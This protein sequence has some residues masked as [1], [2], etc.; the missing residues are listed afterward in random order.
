MRWRGWAA[1]SVV[2][3]AC[4]GVLFLPPI[5]QSE[6]YHRFADTRAFLGVPN[7][8]NVVS[9]FFFLP[10]GVLGMRFV[11][12]KWAKGGTPFLDRRER[13]TYFVFFLAVA[14]TAFG[15][16]Y[17]HWRP[18]DQTLV[19]DRLPMTMGFGSL[20]AATVAERVNL[21]LGLRLL[22]PLL[23]IEAGTVIYW[24]ATQ[25]GGHGDLRPY[26]LAQFGSLLVIVLLVALYPPRYTRGADLLIALGIYGVAKIFEGADR[27]IFSWGGIV[28][29]HTLKHVVAALS[30][31]W[32]LHMLHHRAPRFENAMRPGHL[33]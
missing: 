26:A 12:H 30:A 31:W 19:W 25:S 17:Y 14:L 18:Q 28:S 32:I 15:S 16:A 20:V 4:I 1:I 33:A 10:V 6:T 24:A 11:S 8:L 21:R 9:N 3:L 2:A 13:L 27:M 22:F 23:L 29:G 5:A 7:S